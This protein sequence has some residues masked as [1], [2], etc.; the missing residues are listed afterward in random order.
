MFHMHLVCSTQGNFCTISA[1]SYKLVWDNSYSSFFKKVCHKWCPAYTIA[2]NA[3]LKVSF[4]V[5]HDSLTL[6]TLSIAYD[7]SSP[8][9]LVFAPY[10]KIHKFEHFLVNEHKLKYLMSW[11]HWT[12][13]NGYCSFLCHNHIEL[14]LIH[15]ILPH[16]R[17]SG[18]RWMLCHRLSSRPCPP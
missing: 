10:L 4:P 2:V 9:L 14:A 1:G 8:W 12:S 3:M 5:E 6:R 16:D 7:G 15:L 11:P 17:A 13:T 18:T